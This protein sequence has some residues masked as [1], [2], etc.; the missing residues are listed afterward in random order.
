MAFQ[1]SRC[2]GYLAAAVT[3]VSLAACGSSSVE[4]QLEPSR[5]IAFGDGQSDI[6]QSGSR[7]TVNGVEGRANWT[8]E[9]AAAY[10][11]SITPANQG[12]ASYAWGNTRVAATPDAAGDASTPTLGD[13]IGNFLSSD[14]FSGNELVLLSS[15]TSDVIVVARQA[16]NGE[17]TQA[18]A[19]TQMRTISAQL[20]DQVGRLRDN[21]ARYIVVI[22]TYDLGRS[23][24]ARNIDQVAFLESLSSEFNA[25]FKIAMEDIRYQPN[26]LYVDFEQY[27]NA[28]ISEP[29]WYALNNID[30]PI[31][32]SIDP[33]PGI[34]IG[35][36]QVD[37]ALCTLSTLVS[38]EVDRYGYADDVY[39][40]PAV[41]RQ[42]GNW[43]A[44]LIRDRW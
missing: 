16:L 27:M 15:G 8:E 2:A 25:G 10:G 12:G 39:F 21:G 43:A 1:W 36:G 18:Q 42:F 5:I 29:Q 24:W 40:T 20:R 31:C 6:G 44:G 30:Q 19:M 9:V 23:I 41:Q 3:A 22:G 33:G 34:G 28:V 37:S 14:A 13:Q 11:R 32:N 7:F 35:D 17:I 26:V 38:A 4:S